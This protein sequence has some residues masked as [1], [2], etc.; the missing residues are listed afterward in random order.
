MELFGGAEQMIDA[1]PLD[2]V[3]RRWAYFGFRLLG[4]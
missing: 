2:R 1:D 3:T 4:R